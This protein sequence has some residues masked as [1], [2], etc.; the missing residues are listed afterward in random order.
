VNVGFDE[1]FP[2]IKLSETETGWF[3]SVGN[4]HFMQVNAVVPDDNL[5]S[6]A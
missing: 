1:G 4:G 5:N 2:Q 6:T 3:T